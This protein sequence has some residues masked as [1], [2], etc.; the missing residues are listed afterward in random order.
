MSSRNSSPPSRGLR[1]R[2][3]LTKYR[4]GGPAERAGRPEGWRRCAGGGGGG[5]TTGHLKVTRRRRWARCG[6]RSLGGVV[7]SVGGGSAAATAVV[8]ALEAGQLARL[9][10]RY[11]PSAGE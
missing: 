7:G 9:G 8:L 5:V 11:R 2:M 3:R 1:R 6:G 10:V 4:R